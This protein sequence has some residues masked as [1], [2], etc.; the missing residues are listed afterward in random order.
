MQGGIAHGGRLIEA[1]RRFP[2][3]PAPFIDLSTGINPHP[4][5]VGPLAPELFTRL[6]EPEA[7]DELQQVAAAAYGAVDPAMVVAAPGTQILISLLPHLLGLGRATILGPTYGEHHAAW[8]NAGAT[9]GIEHEPTAFRRAALQAGGAAILCN[10]NNPDGRRCEPGMLLALADALARQGGVLICDE[11]FADL[12]AP[13]PGL[14]P[15]LPHPGLL[16][17][18]SFGKS[19]GLAGIRLGFLLA[20]P[21]P[22]RRVR[23]ALGPWAVSG[24]AL[25]VGRAALA[26]IAWREAAGP[27]LQQECERLD[28]LAVGAGFTQAGGTRLFR[29]FRGSHAG[30]VADAL[31]EAGI[32]VRRFAHDPDLLRFGLPA[33]PH[34]PRLQDALGSG[35]RALPCRDSGGSHAGGTV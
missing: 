28:A 26:D 34:W 6:P 35:I 25:A 13:D 24:A 12:E 17:L 23:M 2:H 33:D 4:Y 15:H 11:A 22:A 21:D 20:S 18:R 19:Y 7:V 5:P 29:L 8:S 27:R 1:G 32:L 31:G 3:A 10:P 16:L 14:A 9:V 30:R